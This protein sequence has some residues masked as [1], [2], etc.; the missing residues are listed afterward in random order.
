M[1]LATKSDGQILAEVVV[2]EKDGTYPVD[3]AMVF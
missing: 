3:H 1:E 2:V